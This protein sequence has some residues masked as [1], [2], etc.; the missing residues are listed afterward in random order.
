[1]MIWQTNTETVE[2]INELI[3][4]LPQSSVVVYTYGAWDLLHPGH[5]TFLSKARELGDFLIVGV[6][7]DKSIKLLKGKDRPA[8]N[9]K[10]RKLV[11]SSLRIVDATINQPEYDPSDIIVKLKK[12]NIL[13]KGN[14]WDYIPGEDTIKKL[15]GILVKPDYTEG[16]STSS[17]VSQ[18]SG[19][20][21]IKSREPGKKE[22][23]P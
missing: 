1:M 17:L 16:F 3:A 5:I 13:A 14:D 11:I 8:Q 19:K 4:K 6:V 9:Q 12:V 23:K 22:P 20:S 15:G 21:H 7:S 2:E 18:I 10:D